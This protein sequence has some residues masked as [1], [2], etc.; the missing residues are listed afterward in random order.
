[1]RLLRRWLLTVVAVA[2][3]SSRVTLASEA[4]GVV[5][6]VTRPYV[7][8]ARL[9]W[10]GTAPRPLRTA[11]WYPV[12]EAAEREIIFDAPPEQRFFVPVV[13]APAARVSQRAQTY[14]LIV[15]SHG[16]G[17][18]ALMM[19]WLGRYLAARGYIVAAVNHHGNTAAE[20]ELAPQGFLLYWERATDLGVVIDQV[21]QDPMFENRID[22][23][24]IGA[25]GFSLGGYTVISAAGGRFDQ[26]RFDRFCRSR[27]RDFTCGP[28]NEFPEAPARFAELRKADPVVRRSLRRSGNSYRD[29]RIKAVFAIAPALGGGF[30]ARALRDVRVPVHIVVGAADDITPPGTNAWRYASLIRN[31][32]LT[33]LAGQVSHYTFLHECTPRGREVIP[34]CRDGETVDRASVHRTVAELALRFFDPLLRPQQ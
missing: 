13:V 23:T 1:M 27:A 18:S 33:T 26:R 29:P 10:A 34:I 21:L 12:D 5:G 16:T 24:R 25:A 8:Q 31:A 4:E 7:D 11:I 19:M 32:Q 17:G 22:R 15:M 20:K 9:N 6:M 14:P 30:G 2:I 28:Q 3:V